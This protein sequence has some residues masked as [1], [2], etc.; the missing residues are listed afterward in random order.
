MWGLMGHGEDSGFHLSEREPW[1]GS[2]RWGRGL[3]RCSQLPL[4]RRGAQTLGAGREL[5]DQG[6][7][8]DGPAGGEVDRREHMGLQRRALGTL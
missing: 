7:G 4:A 8:C 3:T 5:G 2:G 6:G 1:G